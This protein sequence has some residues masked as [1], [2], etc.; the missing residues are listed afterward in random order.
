[1]NALLIFC[2]AMLVNLV[3]Q[4]NLSSSHMPNVQSK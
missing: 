1:M 4:L 2:N 3:F